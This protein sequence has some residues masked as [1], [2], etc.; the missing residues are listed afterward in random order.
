MSHNGEDHTPKL[1][2]SLDSR[3]KFKRSNAPIPASTLPLPLVPPFIIGKE[4]DSWQS[5]TSMDFMTIRYLYR[6]CSRDSEMRR[7]ISSV[8]RSYSIASV[9]LSLQISHVS[10]SYIPLGIIPWA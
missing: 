1:M 2:M 4:E 8:S 7:I 3:K 5:D 9:F 10:L 6:Q